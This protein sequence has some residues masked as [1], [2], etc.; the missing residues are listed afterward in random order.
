MLNDI[1]T[2]V[3]ITDISTRKSFDL[4]NILKANNINILLCDDKSAVMLSKSYGQKIELLRKNGYFESDLIAILEKY[5]ACNLIYFPI[6][7]DTTVLVNDFIEKNNYKNLY[8]N[9]PPQESFEIVRDKALFSKFCEK[10]SLNIPKE[11]S[12]ELL[13]KEPN[14]PSNIIIKPRSGSGSVG[15][16][17]IDSKEELLENSSLDFDRYIIQE[18]LDNSQDIEGAFFLFDK[19]KLLTYYGHKRIR[20]YPKRGGVTVY[21]KCQLNEDLKKLGSELLEKLQWSGIAMVEFLY[22]SKTKQYKIIEVNP[23]SW[24]SLMLSEYCGSEMIS[25]YCLT[26]L[27]RPIKKSEIN[28]NVYI[29]WIFPWD[30]ISYIQSVGRVEGFWRFQRDKTCYIN[31]SYTTW[32]RAFLFMIYNIINP[33]KLK[34]LIKKVMQ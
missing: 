4:A 2:V 16:L 18:R 25:N 8:H 22:D 3:L 5:S 9:L 30:V 27:N 23:R 7:E 31:F 15:I 32:S 21:S 19:G 1:K 26:S 34:R 6:E 28:E 24:G 29:R 11:Y 14:L 13:I 17:F 33:S 20:T 10:N 12:Y